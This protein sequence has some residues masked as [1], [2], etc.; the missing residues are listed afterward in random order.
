MFFVGV[1]TL[2]HQQRLRSFFI[3]LDFQP[4]FYEKMSILKHR[5]YISKA[6]NNFKK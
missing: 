6:K 2:K 3:E 1:A 5:H 4:Q